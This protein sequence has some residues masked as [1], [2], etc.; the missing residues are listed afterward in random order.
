MITSSGIT[1]YNASG[2]ITFELNANS[3]RMTSQENFL[4]QTSTSQNRGVKMDD[5]G[6]RGYN[7][8]GTKTFEIDIYGNATFSGNITASNIYGTTI[9]GG[10]VNG[11]I[12]NGATINGGTINVETDVNVGNIIRLGDS[13]SNTKKT[14]SFNSGTGIQADNNE[15]LIYSNDLYFRLTNEMTVDANYINL[16]HWYSKI[17]LKGTIDVNFANFVN[18]NHI[19]VGSAKRALT[20]DTANQATN[21]D[22]SQ[23]VQ[24]LWI[25]YNSTFVYIR[26]RNGKKT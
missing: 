4:I 8:S 6:I 18:T 13:F 16:G 19:N 17:N 2:G 26:D 3:G 22:E 24:G 5:Y 20:A 1:G 12:I 23:Y 14:I 7:T 21:A 11:T 25:A 15:I 10:T 9:N